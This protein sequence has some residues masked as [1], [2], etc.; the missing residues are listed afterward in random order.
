MVDFDLDLSRARLHR[1]GVGREVPIE[2]DR[3]KLPADRAEVL[4][5]DRLV[6]GRT[7]EHGPVGA[8]GERTI[9]VARG[10]FEPGD[11]MARR[12]VEESHVVPGGQRDQPSV[13]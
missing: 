6:V 13:R 5:M 8:E 3:G 7:G 2:A 4:N 1:R 11:P 12:G 9:L 10:A